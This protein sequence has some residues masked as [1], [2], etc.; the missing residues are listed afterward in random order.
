MIV[1][2]PAATAVITPVEAF[3]VAMVSS[4][5]V[6]AP[7]LLPFD[8]NVVVPFEQIA[9]VPLKVPAF[10]AVVTVT[11]LVAVSFAQPPVPVTTYLMVDVPAATGVITPV[12]EFT[13]A[14]P[15][16]VE[17]HAPPVSPSVVNVTVPSEQSA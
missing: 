14:T 3:T 16:L 2:V 17:L 9:C 15:V 8:V 4:L 5:L 11:V 1:E 7:P 13:V 10:A 12:V 6:H